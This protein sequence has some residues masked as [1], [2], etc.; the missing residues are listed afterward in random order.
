MLNSNA[1][2]I[3]PNIKGAILESTVFKEVPQVGS[4]N[5]DG[6]GLATEKFIR[7]N[8]V[9]EVHSGGADKPTVELSTFVPS[10]LVAVALVTVE[11]IVQVKDTCTYTIHVEVVN[12]AGS[13]TYTHTG[14][15]VTHTSLTATAYPLTTSFT[16]V[17]YHTTTVGVESTC[18]VP[19]VKPSSATD[20]VRVRLVRTSGN[21]ITL[22][23]VR[24]NVTKTLL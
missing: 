17:P 12:S 2:G 16:L 21:G 11:G 24:I 5:V 7:L 15:E 8:A 1:T 14:M 4:L 3:H 6:T 22:D 20:K 18:N 13:V 23:S 9:E 10:E 19:S